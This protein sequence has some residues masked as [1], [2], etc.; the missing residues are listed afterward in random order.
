MHDLTCTSPGKQIHIVHTTVA[1]AISLGDY[2]EAG[3]IVFLFTLA[4]WLESRSSDKV[5]I[6]M[7]FCIIT[8]R[9]IIPKNGVQARMAISSVAN[10]APQVA[11]LADNGLK[12]PVA[13][14]AVGSRLSVKSGDQVPID[15]L[16]VFGKSAVDESSLTGESM[17]VDKEAG[18]TVWAGTLNITGSAFL[19]F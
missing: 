13:E 11:F 19:Y 17:L 9:A 3:S 12:V 15:G 18:A 1:G 4:D 16:V 7:Y 5:I 14:V 10:L 2:L 8:T 6:G